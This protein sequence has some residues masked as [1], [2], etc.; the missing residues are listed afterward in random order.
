M[1]WLKRAVTNEK[2]GKEI[3]ADLRKQAAEGDEDAKAILTLIG[4]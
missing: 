3:L 1:K 4:K 2:G